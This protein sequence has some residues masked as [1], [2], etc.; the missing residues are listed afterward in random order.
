MMLRRTKTV[1]GSKFEADITQQAHERTSRPITFSDLMTRSFTDTLFIVLLN[2]NCQWH[3]SRRSYHRGGGV[4]ASQVE[5]D[6]QR[7]GKP[8]SSQTQINHRVTVFLRQP[9]K[10]KCSVPEQFRQNAYKTQHHPMPTRI[11]QHT[12]SVKFAPTEGRP[13]VLASQGL[14]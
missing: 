14:C 8:V 13:N 6:L 11:E 9:A 12:N 1:L 2:C 10:L 3:L 4:T 5:G 7:V